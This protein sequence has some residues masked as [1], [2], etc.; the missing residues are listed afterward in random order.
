MIDPWTAHMLRGEFEKALLINDE[1][2]RNRQPPSRE[3][4]R[5]LQSIWDGRALDGRRVLVRCYHGLG[6]TIQFIRYVPMLQAVAAEVT[7]WVQPALI[8]VLRTMRCPLTLLP[9]HD[10]VPEYPYD[11][12]IELMELPH[13]F[14]TTLATVPADVPY[15]HVT[16]RRLA[17]DGTIAVWLFPN[18]GDWDLRRHIPLDLLA[19]LRVAGVSL[20]CLARDAG[21]SGAVEGWRIVRGPDDI[22]STAALMAGADIVISADSMAAHLAGAAGVTTWTLLHTESDWRWMEHRADS[23]WYPTMRLFRQRQRGDWRSV[24]DEV[25]GALRMRAA[26]RSFHQPLSPFT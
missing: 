25:A 23:P 11:A 24:V 9:L 19:D 7:V 13:F 4:P 2:L 20:Y 26:A 10:G 1:A 3:V 6:D 8:P 21:S 12:D 14:R 22:L 16:P 15:L 17:D 5:H 18:A